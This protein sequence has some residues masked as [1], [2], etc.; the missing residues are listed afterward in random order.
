M[1]LKWMAGMLLAAS[2]SLPAV[3]EEKDA[4]LPFDEP[5]AAPQIPRKVPA[6]SVQKTVAPKTTAK[7]TAAKS[8]RPAVAK[9]AVPGKK[10]AVAK[11]AAPSRQT[12]K[13]PATSSRKPTPA[14]KTAA[15]SK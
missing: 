14:K 13:K 9:K 11:K 6:A 8:K 7:K 10:P 15:K 1:F 5:A 4:P 3:A 12:A 2:L